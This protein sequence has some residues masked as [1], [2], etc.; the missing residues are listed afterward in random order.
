MQHK[1][2]PLR[3]TDLYSEVVLPC[4]RV[5]VGVTMVEDPKDTIKPHIDAGRL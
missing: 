2:L 5:N 3:D 4:R 1:R